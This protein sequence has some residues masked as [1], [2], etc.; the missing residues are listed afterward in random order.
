MSGWFT[1]DGVGC[2]QQGW[3]RCELTFPRSYAH[4]KNY[5]RL[6]SKHINKKS[7]N[8]DDRTA[9]TYQLH[10]FFF[11]S[12]LGSSGPAYLLLPLS[13]LFHPFTYKMLYHFLYKFPKLPKKRAKPSNP[14]KR[15]IS[16]Y[17]PFHSFSL[18]LCLHLFAR[19]SSSVLFPAGHP[20][21]SQISSTIYE[22]AQTVFHSLTK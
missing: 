16:T 3:T 14:L 10:D 13:L 19:S 17:L 20:L 9:C 6:G 5:I 11:V 7:G 12:L 4:R 21:A 22:L 1:V 2:A 15:M 18:L 8:K